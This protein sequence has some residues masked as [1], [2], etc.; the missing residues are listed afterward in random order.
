MKKILLLLSFVLCVTLAQAQSMKMVVDT[1]GNAVG[2]YVSASGNYYTVDVQDT[3]T[4]PKRGHRVVTFSAAN[5]QGV[6]FYKYG[7]TGNLNVRKQPTTNSPV[8]T[9]IIDPQP[10]GYVPECHDCLGKVKG[11]YKV[12]VNG[13]VGYVRG[14]LVDWDGMCTF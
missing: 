8:I 11:W 7:H 2:R 12:R 14:D 13:K 1:R 5:G 6:V 9:Q 3:G 10:E 4:V